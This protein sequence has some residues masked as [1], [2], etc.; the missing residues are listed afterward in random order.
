MKTIVALLSLFAVL[1]WLIGVP[2]VPAQ[3]TLG[4]APAGQQSVLYWT[5]TPT[6]YMVQS[7]HQSDHA[8]LGDG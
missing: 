5:T 3:P 4:I 6:N 2:S 1:P 7:H 8:R